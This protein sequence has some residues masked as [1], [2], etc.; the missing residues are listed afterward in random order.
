VELINNLSP[1]GFYVL[2]A[3]SVLFALGMIFVSN[4]VRAGFL[5]VGSFTS[6]A[7]IY[8]ILNANF[9]AV[10][11]ILIYAVG[12]VLV[13]VFAIMLSKLNQKADLPKDPEEKKELSLRNLIA[14]FMSLAIFAGLLYVINSMDWNIIRKLSMAEIHEANLVEFSKF[15]TPIIGNHMLSIYI[16]PFELIAVL[17]LAVLVGVVILSKKKI[18]EEK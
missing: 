6:I 3:S 13:I 9:V 4:L 2:A 16:L 14:A 15:Y 17:L 12:I 18:E 5:L 10:S 8:F 11:Q 1:L 7:G